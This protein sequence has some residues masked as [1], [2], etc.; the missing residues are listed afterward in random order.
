MLFHSW[1]V[2]HFNRVDNSVTIYSIS[3]ICSSYYYTVGVPVLEPS[4][5][6]YSNNKTLTNSYRFNIPP[7]KDVA[8]YK[9]LGRKKEYL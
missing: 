8:H 2:D 4:G 5:Y 1:I 9:N 3:D 6:L 7:E